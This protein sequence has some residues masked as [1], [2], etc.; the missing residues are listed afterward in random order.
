MSA[1]DVA[2]L[3]VGVAG[4]VLAVV[5]YRQLVGHPDWRVPAA[6]ILDPDEETRPR[7]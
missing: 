1:L 7:G 2:G 5:A 6:S 4:L 3:V